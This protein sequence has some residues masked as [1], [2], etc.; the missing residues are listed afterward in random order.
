M[1]PGSTLTMLGGA[2]EGTR[3]F[4]GRP[5]GVQPEPRDRGIHIL[6]TAPGEVDQDQRRLAGLGGCQTGPSLS[7]P[8]RACADSIAGTIPSVRESNWKASIAS[9]SLIAS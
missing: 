2:Q 5:G 3:G 1:W 6:V 9:A 7:A 4:R 8:A